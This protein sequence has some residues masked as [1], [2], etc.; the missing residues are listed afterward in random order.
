MEIVQ[1]ATGTKAQKEEALT[2]KKGEPWL[3]LG[4]LP[5]RNFTAFRGMVFLGSFCSL[6]WILGPQV[7]FS[8]FFK[9]LCI[10]HGQPI[11]RNGS[12]IP[13]CQRAFPYN[14]FG[15][16]IQAQEVGKMVWGI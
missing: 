1:A 15:T 3:V 5:K 2:T 14:V 13:I 7:A 6:L 11:S 8:M 9:Y 4:A 16:I 12:F 10:P